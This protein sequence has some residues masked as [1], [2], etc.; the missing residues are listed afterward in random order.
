MPVTPAHPNHTD[1]AAQDIKFPG[2][3]GRRPGSQVVLEQ[4]DG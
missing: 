3:L 4:D 2:K 1:E